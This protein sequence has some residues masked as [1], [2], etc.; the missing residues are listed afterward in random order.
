MCISSHFDFQC[1]SEYKF[2]IVSLIDLS[3]DTNYHQI[4]YQQIMDHLGLLANPGTTS[5]IVP[6]ALEV[7]Q[8]DRCMY[9]SDTRYRG[10]NDVPSR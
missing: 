2:L 6:S 1:D 9:C 7:V 3:P 4:G 8:R 5:E 10:T